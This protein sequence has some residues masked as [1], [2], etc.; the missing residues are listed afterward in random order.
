[1]VIVLAFAS[2]LTLFFWGKTLR[3]VLEGTENL[4]RV[5]QQSAR[6]RVKN[7]VLHEQIWVAHNG[8]H[9]LL[10][11]LPVV[12]FAGRVVQKCCQSVTGR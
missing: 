3:I 8:Q 10:A 6:L 1:M 9:I 7:P 11:F 4:I 5:F 2:S 12:T